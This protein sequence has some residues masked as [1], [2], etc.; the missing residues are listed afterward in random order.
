MTKP[1][2]ASRPAIHLDPELFGR[3]HS[4]A[5]RQGQTVADWC[6]DL[7]EAALGLCDEP[8][9]IVERVHRLEQIVAH[10][11]NAAPVTPAQS[12]S[13]FLT[14]RQHTALNL[15]KSRWRDGQGETTAADL[16]GEAAGCGLEGANAAR[17]ARGVL[18]ALAKKK[19][20]QLRKVGTGISAR[21]LT[22]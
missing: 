9:S 21:P 4:A 11:S 15:V 6:A 2:P 8:L 14:E 12:A 17:M 5:L 1:Q 10:M 16:V 13:H 20:V 22:T 3:I 7:F 18:S 19:L